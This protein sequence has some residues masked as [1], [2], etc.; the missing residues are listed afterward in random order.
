MIEYKTTNDMIYGTGESVDEDRVP[1][2]PE[3][4][5]WE[6]HSM[7]ANNTY[8]FYCWKRIKEIAVK[9]TSDYEAGYAA[10]YN[11]HP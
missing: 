4:D 1:T 11:S 9:P 10:G 7:T 5:G 6:L 8:I 3:G 2:R